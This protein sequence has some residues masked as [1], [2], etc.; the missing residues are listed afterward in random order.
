MQ[1]LFPKFDVDFVLR[2][3]FFLKESDFYNNIR[4]NFLLV[5]MLCIDIGHKLLFFNV[6][7]IGR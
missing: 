6:R 7:R 5:Y 4:Y 2:S 3:W 1:K